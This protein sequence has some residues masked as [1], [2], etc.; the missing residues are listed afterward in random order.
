VEISDASVLQVTSGMLLFWAYPN[1]DY[2]CDSSANIVQ[3]P[4]A[5]VQLGS[6]CV[7]SHW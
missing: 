5:S 3:P 2:H 6:G 1:R 7:V 4:V